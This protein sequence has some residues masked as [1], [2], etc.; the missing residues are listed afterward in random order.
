MFGT[1][2]VPARHSEKLEFGVEPDREHAHTIRG[3]LIAPFGRAARLFKERL[4]R[5]AVPVPLAATDRK[6]VY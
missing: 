2:Y 4:A 5:R 3:E 6:Q 1:L